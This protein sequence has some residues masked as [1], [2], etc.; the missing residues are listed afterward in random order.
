MTSSC[1]TITLGAGRLPLPGCFKVVDATRKQRVPSWEGRKS[2]PRDL[3]RGGR[4][5]TELGV[6]ASLHAKCVTSLQFTSISR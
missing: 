4:E 5:E 2:R 6:Q 3:A 1:V